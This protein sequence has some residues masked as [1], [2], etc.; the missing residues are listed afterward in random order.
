MD[1]LLQASA[2]H[3]PAAFREADDVTHPPTSQV[4]LQAASNHKRPQEARE[5]LADLTRDF[6]LGDEVS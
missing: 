5:A 3:I 1:Y 2:M 6:Q 4:E